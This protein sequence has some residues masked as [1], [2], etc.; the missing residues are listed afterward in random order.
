MEN[1]ETIKDDFAF[2]DQWEE[3]YKYIIDLGRRLAP[4][5]ESEKTDINKVRG[6]ASQ[7]WLVF[8]PANKSDTLCFRGDSDAF[9]VKGLVGLIISLLS[10]QTLQTIIDMDTQKALGALGL[11]EHLTPQRSNGLAAMVN[12]IKD[13]ARQRLS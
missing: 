5:Q 7:V 6:C 4:L 8:D 12:R 1:F 11:N 10:G 13:E 3:R 2:L 9:I